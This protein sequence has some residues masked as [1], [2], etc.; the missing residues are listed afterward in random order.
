MRYTTDLTDA[1]WQLIHYCF[2]KPSK[3]G[4]PPAAQLSGTTQRGVLHRA[5]RLPVAQSAE[6][7]RALEHGLSDSCWLG[8]AEVNEFL[9][10]L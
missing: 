3:T 5:H 2:P 10:M 9:N 6:G 1:E 8:W 7:L 4:P